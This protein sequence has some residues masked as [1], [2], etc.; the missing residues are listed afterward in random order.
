MPQKVTVPMKETNTLRKPPTMMFSPVRREQNELSV[1]A[2]S[3]A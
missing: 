1:S 2:V 3:E